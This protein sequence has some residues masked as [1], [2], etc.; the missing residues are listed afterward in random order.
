MDALLSG[1]TPLVEVR[2][3]DAEHRVIRAQRPYDFGGADPQPGSSSGLLRGA[4]WGET[5][6]AG[7]SAGAVTNWALRLGD[8]LDKDDPIVDNFMTAQGKG[9]KRGGGGGGGGKSDQRRNTMVRAS[10]RR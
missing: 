10:H 2:S 7:G 1:R 8:V 9:S 4:N 6:A 5:G 3:R